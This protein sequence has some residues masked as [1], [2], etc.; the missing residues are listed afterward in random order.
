MPARN[1]P[2]AALR[3]PLA[4]RLNDRQWLTVDWVVA[5]VATG[6]AL[7]NVG[8]LHGF[9]CQVPP[10]LTA[11]LAAAGTL[12]VAVRRIWPVPVLGVVTVVCG[13][14]TAHGRVTDLVDLALG[15]AIYTAAVRCRRRGVAIALLVGVEAALGAGALAATFSSWG[16][17]DLAR[18]LLVA[19]ALWFAGD[20]VRE[21]RRYLA[22]LAEQAALQQRAEA[23]CARR[24]IR[25]ERVR[26][27]RELHDVVAHS[28]SVVTIQAGVGRKIEAVRP[29][30]ALRALRAVEVTGRGALEELRR[31]LGLLRDDAEQPSLEPVPGI[32][33][34]EALA[35]RVRAA[36]IPVRLAVTRDAAELAPAISLTA[37]RIVQEALTNV[38]KHARQADASVRVQADPDGVRITVTD[39]GSPPSGTAA[40]VS[41]G[42]PAGRHGIVGMRE[43]AVA[44]GGTLDAGPVPGGGFR[45]TAFLPVSGRVA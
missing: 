3:P 43:R 28:L 22:G 19:G 36:G 23:E 2:A 35:D 24:A 27:A 34:L 1:H 11:I 18:S 39:N 45:V 44:F 33:D 30:E 38:V 21:R 26:I 12:P 9:R 42:G 41:A 37:Y 16:Q 17:Q 29:G 8:L 31:I 40:E 7:F 4:Y 5:V 14:L 25:E 13:V 20:S 32:G 15:M 10:S 6:I